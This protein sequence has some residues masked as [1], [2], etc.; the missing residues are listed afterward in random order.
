MCMLQYS[1]SA[2]CREKLGELVLKEIKVKK[3]GWYVNMDLHTR[4]SGLDT[5]SM[6]LIATMYKYFY[7]SLRAALCTYDTVGIEFSDG[8]STC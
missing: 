7:C 8:G 2:F 1:C 5:K 6:A 3:D 4:K